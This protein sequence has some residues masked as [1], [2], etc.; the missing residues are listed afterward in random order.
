MCV[1][2]HHIESNVKGCNHLDLDAAAG[3]DF[4]DI[5][6]V[7]SAIANVMGSWWCSTKPISALSDLP[8]KTQVSLS[9]LND[10]NYLYLLTTCDK[11]FMSNLEGNENGFS[12]VAYSFYPQNKFSAYVLI[13]GISNNPYELPEKTVSYGMRLM[14][15]SGKMRKERRYPQVLEYLGWCSWDAFHMDVSHEGLLQKAQEIKDKDIPVRWMII[16]DMWAYCPNNCVRSMKT[17][18]LYSFEADPERFKLG[19]KGA[20]SDLKEKFG[21]KVGVWHPTTG[22]WYGIDPDGTVAKD[23]AD[24][25]V[26]NSDGMLLPNPTFEKFF[27]FYYGFHSFLRDCGANFVKV[28]NQSST[29]R[30]YRG[31]LPAGIACENLHQA[32]EAS[33]GVCFDGDLINCMG[34]GNENFW[35]RPQS[36]VNRISNDF[37][38]ENREWFIKHLLQCSYNA[39][40]QCCVYTGDWDMWWSDDEQAVKNA[41]LR[42]MSGGPVYMSDKLDRSIKK[43]V[44]PIIYSDGRIIRLQDPA[45][46]VKECLVGDYQHNGK[47]FKVFNRRGEVGVLAAFNL[48][49]QEHMVSGE[50]SVSDIYGLKSGKYVLYDYFS[51]TA[52]IITDDKI[53]LTLNNYDDFRLYYLLPLG[54]ERIVPIGLIDK[55]MAPATFET[56]DF[57]KYIITEGGNF[58]VYSEQDNIT[59][60]YGDNIITPKHMGNNI[61]SFN[62]PKGNSKILFTIIADSLF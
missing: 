30:L 43:V 17:R 32:V 49:E 54:K 18:E 38:P 12:V 31:M 57:G 16:D 20:I 4:D 5:K 33:V 52:Q 15:K 34:M 26:V 60:K 24:S 48:D 1:E 27:K 7:K 40:I 56:L 8:P 13:V 9:V 21:L 46:P 22:Y 39:Y 2:Y 29:S 58:C 61:Y 37:Q 11:E 28:D 14:G 45:M 10:N 44:M 19:L 51:K 25:L 3:I 6:E 41:V 55:Y 35:N 36:S 62:I 59:L 42:A 53:P 50:V 47:I 23:Y